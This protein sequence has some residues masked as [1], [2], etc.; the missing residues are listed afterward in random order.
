MPRKLACLGRKLAFRLSLPFHD[1]DEVIE[2]REERPVATIFA[3]GGEVA[4]RN[5]E[6]TLLPSLVAAPAVVTLGGGA[7]EARANREV[8]AAAGFAPLWLA[9]TPARAWDRAGQDPNRPLAQAP[10]A[11]LARWAARLPAWSLAPMVLPFGH[12]SGQLAAALLGAAP[13]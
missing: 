5:L 6:A 2:A 12:S 8:V 7:W 9:E 4:F 3:E 13:E 11:F 10:A 1:L